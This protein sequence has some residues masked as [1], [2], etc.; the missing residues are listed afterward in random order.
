MDKKDTRF[1]TADTWTTKVGEIFIKHGLTPRYINKTGSCIMPAPKH[2]KSAMQQ[3]NSQKSTQ[4][5]K[6]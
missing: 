2:L 4:K 5:T 6:D 1:K 3:Q